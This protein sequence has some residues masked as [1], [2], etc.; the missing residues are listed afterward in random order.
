MPVNNNLPIVPFP[1]KIRFGEKPQTDF[2]NSENCIK[3]TAIQ[4][5]PKNYKEICY[6][7]IM[8]TWS[9]TVKDYSNPSQEE[10]DKTFNDLI[11]GKVL[12]N[13]M[14]SLNFT[15]LIEGLTHIEWSHILRHREGFNAWHFQCT[16]D[17]FLSMDSAFIPS[18]IENSSFNKDYRDLTEKAKKLYQQMVDSGITLMDA[19]Y[20]L[21]RNQRYFIYVTINLKSIIHFI[22]QRI[23]EA[24]QP[25]QDNILAKRMFDEVI[26]TIPELSKVISFKCGKNCPFIVSPLSRNTRLYLPNKNHAELMEFNPANFLYDKTRKEMGVWFNQQDE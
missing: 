16:G 14:E 15:F 26:K 17:R 10:L 11:T 12:P 23:C 20:I 9:D 5:P 4:T 7:M 6:R 2:Y 8:A 1:E 24:I 13:S 25:E 22:K 3:V 18:S 21:P 19:R